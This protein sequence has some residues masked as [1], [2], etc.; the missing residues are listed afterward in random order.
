MKAQDLLRKRAKE[1]KELAFKNK[2]YTQEQII[3]FMIKYPDLIERPI[4]VKEDV[5]ILGRPVEKIEEIL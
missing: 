3:E 5:V 2:K 4:I 1:Y